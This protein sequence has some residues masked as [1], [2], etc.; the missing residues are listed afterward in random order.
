MTPTWDHELAAMIDHTV[1]K[2]TASDEDIRLLCD[3]VKTYGFAAAVVPPCYVAQAVRHMEGSP[4]PVCSIVS[5]PLG[6]NSPAGKAEEAARLIDDGCREVDMVMNIGAFL[7]GHHDVTRDEVR[8]AAGACRGRAI[9]KLIIETAYLDG[10]AIKLA[11]SIAVDGGVDVVKTSTGFGPRGAS[12]E[13]V[14]LIKSVVHDGAGVKASGGI[15]TRE[16]ALALVEAGATRIGC[17]TSLDLITN[18]D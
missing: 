15:R 8:R 10:D 5:F 12:V 11:A 7:S 14:K 9:L 17:S 2:P 6:S 4:I 16:F 1:L 13:D 3:E 18:P